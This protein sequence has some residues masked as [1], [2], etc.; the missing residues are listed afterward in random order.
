ML[1]KFESLESRILKMPDGLGSFIFHSNLY[2]ISKHNPSEDDAV[3]ERKYRNGI[4]NISLYDSSSRFRI[5]FVF[6]ELND[7]QNHILE[8]VFNSTF[9]FDENH[10]I[11]LY[12]FLCSDN[13]NIVFY[14]VMNEIAY[15]V[16]FNQRTDTI[17]NEFKLILA[18]QI[19][20]RLKSEDF[21]ID[22]IQ[23]KNI[24]SPSELYK[25]SQRQDAIIFT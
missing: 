16:S 13:S 6:I 18:N 24:F 1:D 22:Y 8:F 25:L 7:N 3:V 20:S 9:Y 10:E 17:V 21:Y 5:P 19:S 12:D 23:I 2:L 15:D 4:K 11:L 14:Y